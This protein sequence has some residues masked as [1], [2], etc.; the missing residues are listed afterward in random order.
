MF[1]RHLGHRTKKLQE[2]LHEYCDKIHNSSYFESGKHFE[3][4]NFIIRPVSSTRF[5]SSSGMNL[6]TIKI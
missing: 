2:P 1:C 4:F 5:K 3:I 6:M